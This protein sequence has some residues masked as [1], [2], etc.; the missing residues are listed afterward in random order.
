MSRLAAFGALAALTAL[1]GM[2]AAAPAA[3]QAQNRTGAQDVVV[4]VPEWTPAPAPGDDGVISNA[5][6]RWGINAESGAAGFAPGTCNF[7]SAGVA[8]STGSS[9]TWTEADGLY[10]ARDGAVRIEKPTADGAWKLASFDDICNDPQGQRLTTG[11]GNS[12]GN[13]VVIDGGSGSLT[14]G[15]LDIQWRGSFTVAYYSG[16]TYWS[17]TDPTLHIDAS[18]SGRLTGTASGFGADM[19]DASSWLPIAP[20]SITLAEVRRVQTAEGT[21]FTVVPEYRGVEVDTAET[22]QLRTG[23]HWGAFPQ[24]FVDFQTLTGQNSYWYSSGGAADQRKPASALYVSYDAAAPIAVPAPPG[25]ASDSDSASAPSNPVRMPP[26]VPSPNS[27]PTVPTA[28]TA[29]LAATASTTTLP[30]RPS[31]VPDGAFGM[32]PLVLPLLGTAAALGLSIIAVLSLM[33]V[34]PWQRR[35]GMP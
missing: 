7:L 6:L 19:D 11:K 22:A 28:A 25:S 34:L 2:S 9:R 18:G 35:P 20:R 8:G 1:V 33:Q 10:R 15:V 27:V 29:V 26:T 31:L 4:V 21:G 23:P 30:Q 12:T 13:Q 3:A 24:S 14:A 32:S 17:V 5:Q 16:M